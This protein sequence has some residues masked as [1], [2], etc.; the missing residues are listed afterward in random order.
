MCKEEIFDN[1]VAG[2]L[3]RGMHHIPVDRA[4]GMSSYATALRALRA[5]EI[6]GVFPEATISRSFE[7]K[8][9]KTGAVRMAASTG[10]PLLPTVIWGS[11]RVW[12]KG[13]SKRFVGK[14]LPILVTVGPPMHVGRRDDH[15]AA[16]VELRLRMQAMLEESQDR[17]P[18]RPAGEDDRWWLPARLSGT[19]PTPEEAARLDEADRLRRES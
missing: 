13:R 9:I 16:A 18:D 11:Q 8:D 17:Y 7:I 15:E 10:V 1:P 12:T 5:G 14:P 19:A 3:M 2:P 4:A 6:V